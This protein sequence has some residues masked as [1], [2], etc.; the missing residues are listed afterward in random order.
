VTVPNVVGL[1]QQSA[2]AVLQSA[3]LP[4]SDA[5]ASVCGTVPVGSVVTE[6][7][8]AGTAVSPGSP[9]TISVCEP[10]QVP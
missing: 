6:A 1:T 4:V 5:S 8:S 9:V 7:P 3:G 10:V 2:T